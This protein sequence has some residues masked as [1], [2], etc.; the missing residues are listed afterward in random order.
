MDEKAFFTKLVDN[1]KD[2]TIFKEDEL[3]KGELRWKI[4]IGTDQDGWIKRSQTA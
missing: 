3:K 1:S 4:Q 2:E